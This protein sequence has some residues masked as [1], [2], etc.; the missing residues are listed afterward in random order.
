MAE[1]SLLPCL[2]CYPDTSIEIE[3]HRDISLEVQAPHKNYIYEIHIYIYMLCSMH[4]IFPY[5]IINHHNLS[6][7][8]FGWNVDVVTVLWAIGMAVIAHGETCA[9][10]DHESSLGVINP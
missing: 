9:H 5:Y 8:H 6:E 10:G 4:S 3:K 7:Y 1:V 2:T